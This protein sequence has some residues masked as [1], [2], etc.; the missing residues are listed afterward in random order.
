M[1]G[2]NSFLEIPNDGPLRTYNKPSSYKPNSARI[3]P[4]LGDFQL[5]KINR[6]YN[7]IYITFTVH[8]PLPAKL[9]MTW[10]GQEIEN[11]FHF[12]NLSC[13]YRSLV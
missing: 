11:L 9:R 1:R 6:I 7:K 2:K 3:F 12:S 8:C 13:Y 4:S 5:K 10:W